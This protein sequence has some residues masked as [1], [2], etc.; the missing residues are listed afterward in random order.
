MEKQPA[1]TPCFYCDQMLFY[2]KLNTTTDHVIPKMLGGTN[3]V[4]NKVRACLKCNALKANYLPKHLS[5]LLEWFYIPREQNQ[6]K[7][8]YFRK[9]FLKCVD[10]EMNHIPKYKN[11][12]IKNPF[13]L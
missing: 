11:V 7:K 4:K 1:P 2:K 9:V 12:M 10:L 6:E 8:E 3:H 13:N 5:E